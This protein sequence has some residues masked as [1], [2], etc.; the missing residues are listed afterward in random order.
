MRQHTN[1][2]CTEHYLSNPILGIH[3]IVLSKEKVVRRG[4]ATISGL[5]GLTIP[6][7][8]SPL[9]D[10]SVLLHEVRGE[11]K[12]PKFSLSPIPEHCEPKKFSAFQH[13]LP[14]G[15]NNQKK[16]SPPHVTSV[17]S[18][19]AHFFQDHANFTATSGTA[20]EPLLNYDLSESEISFSLLKSSV[21]T[22]W[23]PFSKRPSLRSK[24]PLQFPILEY[25]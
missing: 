19:L 18:T 24:C 7:S 11:H 5:T 14:A 17:L 13:D 2:P 6:P 20:Y 9:P 16:E 25:R 23:R 4:C 10:A 12:A 21:P 8:P 15:P 22:P 1:A 3:D